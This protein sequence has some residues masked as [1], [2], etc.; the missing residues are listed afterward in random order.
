MVRHRNP[1]DRNTA[2]YQQTFTFENGV[3][4]GDLDARIIPCTISSADGSNNFQPAVAEGST[5]EQILE[6]MNTW[7][8]PYSGVSFDGDGTLIAQ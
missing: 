1:S 6:D 5:R 7:S 4:T 2:I 8:A 3:L